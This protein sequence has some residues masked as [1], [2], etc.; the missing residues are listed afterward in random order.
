MEN[1]EMFK[2]EPLQEQQ[3]IVVEENEQQLILDEL[4]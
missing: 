2:S 3:V 1:K 4:E